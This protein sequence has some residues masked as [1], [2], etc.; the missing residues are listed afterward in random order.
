MQRTLDQVSGPSISS[1]PSGLGIFGNPWERGR[2]TRH[3][4]NRLPGVDDV[5]VF[6]IYYELVIV[7]DVV[8]CVVSSLSGE[9]FLRPSI[10]SF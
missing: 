10:D 8:N 9:P 5:E 2:E 6:F 7:F 4:A 3:P 1:D